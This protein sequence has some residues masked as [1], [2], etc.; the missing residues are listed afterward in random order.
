MVCKPLPP[1]FFFK[2]KKQASPLGKEMQIPFLKKGQRCCVQLSAP[3]AGRCWRSSGTEER[4][5]APWHVTVRKCK[6]PGEHTNSTG[7]PSSSCPPHHLFPPISLPYSQNVLGK[8]SCCNEETQNDDEYN[9]T[10]CIYLI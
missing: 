3:C 7:P 6:H 1:P 8:M 10:R 4:L 9:T 5:G 2:K